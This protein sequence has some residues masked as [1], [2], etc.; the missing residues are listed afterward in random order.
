MTQRIAVLGGTG[1]LGRRV[2]PQL[3]AGAANTML[4]LLA[5]GGRPRAEPLLAG[6]P[7]IKGCA[8]KRLQVV[9]GGVGG[10]NCGLAA[11]LDGA[12]T[13]FCALS[14]P[15]DDPDFTAKHT[16]MIGR[17]IESTTS[18][19]VRRLVL[20]GGAGLLG[21]PGGGEAGGLRAVMDGPLSKLAQRFNRQYSAYNRAHR[22]NYAA[23]Q[24]AA[25]PE[26]TVLCPGFMLDVEQRYRIDAPGGGRCH[27]PPRVLVDV[28]ETPL[29]GLGGLVATYD[30]VAEVAARAVLAPTVPGEPPAGPDT[31]HNKLVGVATDDSYVVR[32]AGGVVQYYLPGVLREP[33]LL[34]ADMMSKRSNV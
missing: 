2:W 23:L 32:L 5:R 6:R 4:S 7:D 20:V 16:E 1:A 11:T 18:A 29:W 14:P 15:L 24:A 26:Y 25:L 8:H 30:E 31:Y 22:Q 9:D 28:N 33:G 17:V 27:P 3:L 10:A 21:L 13:V 34:W 12:D 19:G